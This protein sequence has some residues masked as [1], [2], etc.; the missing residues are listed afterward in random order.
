ML[1]PI[2]RDGPGL[3]IVLGRPVRGQGSNWM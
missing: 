3:N 1:G 2:V